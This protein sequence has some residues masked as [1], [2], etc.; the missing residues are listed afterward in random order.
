MGRNTVSW[1]EDAGIQRNPAGGLT[2]RCSEVTVWI[3][4]IPKCELEELP[5]QGDRINY[6]IRSRDDAN[7]HI[8][9]AGRGTQQDD[10]NTEMR[11]KWSI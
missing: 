9:V 10:E 3:V 2:Q 4:M 7:R 8:G 11:I 5:I 6:V 1:R